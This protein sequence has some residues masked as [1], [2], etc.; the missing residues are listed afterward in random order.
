MGGLIA[1]ELARYCRRNQLPM[2]Q[3]LCVS[4]LE[5]PQCRLPPRR[6]HELDDTDL[7][8]AL[9]DY[10]GTPAA[11]LAQRELMDLLLPALRADFAMV[12]DYRYRPAAPL[13]I[14][15]FKQPWIVS[16]PSFLL[17]LLLALFLLHKHVTDA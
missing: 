1:F 17:R 14:V 15:L 8:A 9:E 6:L 13:P 2:P 16:L 11:A 10:N 4:A 12:A 7:L 3:Q 5:A